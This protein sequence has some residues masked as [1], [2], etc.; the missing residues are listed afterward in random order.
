MQKSSQL[1]IEAGIIPK[2]I[3]QQLVN[4][5]FLPEDSIESHGSRQEALKDPESPESQMFARALARA[6]S[7]DI[8]DIRETELDHTGGYEVVSLDFGNVGGQET[9]FVDKLHRLIVPMEDRWQQLES[10]RFK[11]DEES[12][13]VVK[14]EK[15]YQGDRVSAL[16]IYVESKEVTGVTLD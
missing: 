9:M 5:R 8:A 15:R 4:W 12:R 11:E 2:N 3:L 7:E 6:I 13:K 14:I 1:L 10:V 16:V